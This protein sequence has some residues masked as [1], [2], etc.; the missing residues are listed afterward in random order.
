MSK[1]IKQN[2]ADSKKMSAELFCLTY[3]AMVTEMLKDYED[4][5]DVTIQ[6]DKMGF[7]MGTRLADDFLAKNANVPRCVDTRQIA[8]VL[9]RN[10]IPC[11]LGISATASSWTSGD[12]EFTITLEANPLT[13]LVQVPAH[14]VSAGLSYS[15]LIAGA[16]RGALEAVHFKVYASATD[17]GANTEIRIR[18]DQVLKDSLPAGEDD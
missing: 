15:Q 3:G 5:K 1:A 18:F 17:T 2:L 14:L 16:I 4:P 10:A 12:R 8:D 7:N 6:L 11:Y 13:E 9:C